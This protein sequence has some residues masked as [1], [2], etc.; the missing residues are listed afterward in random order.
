MIERI[1]STIL[2]SLYAPPEPIQEIPGWREVSSLLSL[3][4]K[5]EKP[6]SYW[7]TITFILSPLIFL[8]DWL[9]DKITL[10]QQEIE[11]GETLFGDIFFATATLLYDRSLG[12]QKLQKVVGSCQA[13]YHILAHKWFPFTDDNRLL[14]R[15]IVKFKLT[16]H[17][18]LGEEAEVEKCRALL[19]EL[20]FVFSKESYNEMVDRILSKTKPGKTNKIRFHLLNFG[21]R[22]LVD[23]ACKHSKKKDPIP[24]SPVP[25]F[26]S[27]EPLPTED[28]PIPHYWKILTQLFSPLIVFVEWLSRKIILTDKEIEYGEELVEDAFEGT[29]YL[30]KDRS[31]GEL[32]LKKVVQSCDEF[33]YLLGKKWLPNSDSNR[34]IQQKLL[35]FKLSVCAL[36]GDKNQVEKCQKDLK[37]LGI[38][39]PTG[40]EKEW[41]DHVLENTIPRNNRLLTFLNKVMQKALYVNEVFTKKKEVK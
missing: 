37:A 7:D 33:A 40:M 1:A 13:L 3:G 11:T 2:P 34:F 31:E 29:L 14:R 23:Y 18:L 36:L 4:I 20:G 27:S 19:K 39:F 9:I 41:Q 15:A 28:I 25:T 17:I 8:Y 22:K 30:L 38:D 32:R 10:T 21:V 12:E 35:K 6:S 26:S 16:A 5:E 24:P